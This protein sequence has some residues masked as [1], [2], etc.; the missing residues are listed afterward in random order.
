MEQ[1]EIFTI[2]SP[3]QGICEVNNRGYCKGC[4]RSREERFCWNKMTE[5]Q[6]KLVVDL[7]QRR[8]KRVMAKKQSDSV[9][10]TS[11]GQDDLFKFDI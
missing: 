10:S 1:I 7:C 8:K 2:P 11:Q 3:C 9:S 5:H 4:F 6:K